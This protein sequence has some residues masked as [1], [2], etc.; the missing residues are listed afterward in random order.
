MGGADGERELPPEGD[1]VDGDHV[2]GA[3]V[4]RALHR[5]DAHP[6][7]AH[8]HHGVPGP[9]A[10][11]V[12]RRT[13]PVGTLQAIS[14]AVS[15]GSHGWIL[16]TDV[17]Q[18]GVPGE[19]AD[20]AEPPSSSPSSRKGQVPV[21][22]CPVAIVAPRLHR[23]DRPEAHQRQVPQ[24]G[25]KLATTWSPGATRLTPGPTASTRPEPSWPPTIG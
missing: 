6:A 4:H 19:G 23:L 14:A 13:Q 2:R 15:S 10:A 16:M 20:H 9:G 8:D 24:A 18:Q 5:V 12:H 25:R 21:G 22:S 17:V 1:R 11:G 3:G 7:G